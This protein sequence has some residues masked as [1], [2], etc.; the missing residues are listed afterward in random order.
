MQYIKFKLR[1]WFW[2]TVPVVGFVI[3]LLELITLLAA[4]VPGATKLSNYY[5]C[6]ATL[7]LPAVVPTV[8]AEIIVLSEVPK[9]LCVSLLYCHINKC[10]CRCRTTYRRSSRARIH[11][12]CHHRRCTSC[13]FMCNLT[14]F[15]INLTAMYLQSLYWLTFS[16]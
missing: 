1:L 9:K 6:R 16:W 7:Y 8:L 12:G 10:H 11:H 13:K 14:K 5:N 4:V 2:S 15:L 3:A